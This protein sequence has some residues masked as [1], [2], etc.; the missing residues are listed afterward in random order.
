MNA[1]YGA[2]AVYF[3]VTSMYTQT[4]IQR[5]VAA[6]LV[7]AIT[8]IAATACS[9][10]PK[11]LTGQAAGY[12]DAKRDSLR[13]PYTKADIDFMSGMISHH[14]QAI[15][16]AT[17]APTH[18]ASPAIIRLTERVVNA[19]TDEI[20]MMQGWLRDRKQIVPDANPKGMKMMMGGMEHVMAMPGMLT[21]EQMAK[22]DAARGVEFDRHF[23]TYMIQHHRGAVS[24]VDVLMA[25]NGAAQDETVFKFSNDMYIDQSTEIVRMIQMVLEIGGPVRP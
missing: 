17:W 21:D 7:A 6:T 16:M 25:N 14:A 9:S 11:P 3:S 13:Y 15:V 24:M 19:Q 1:P 23:L 8:V 22:L 12:A 18:G 5:V 10:N 20:T 2:G 4:R